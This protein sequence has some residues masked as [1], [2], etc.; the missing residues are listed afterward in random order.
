VSDLKKEQKTITD[1]SE[2]VDIENVV[3]RHDLPVAQRVADYIRQIK[4]PYC[5]RSHGVVVRISFAGKKPFE[6][7]LKD[8]L[9]ARDKI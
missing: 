5:Y 3:I 9:Y 2:L 7:C 6:E 8:A 4:N 1:T